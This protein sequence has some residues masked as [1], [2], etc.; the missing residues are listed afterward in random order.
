[1]TEHRYPM[2]NTPRLSQILPV[3]PI[4]FITVSPDCDV[5]YRSRL[6][7]NRNA[8]SNGA[9]TFPLRA[10]VMGARS[11]SRRHARV[12]ASV[13]PRTCF[14]LLRAYFSATFFTPSAAALALT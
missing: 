2:T 9:A 10:L 7:E 6:A 1:V 4:R 3:N 11:L 13:T 8:A 5:P 14:R 12:A